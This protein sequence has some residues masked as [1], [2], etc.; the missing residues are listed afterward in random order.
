MRNRFFYLRL[1]R[2]SLAL[3]GLCDLACAGALVLTPD[4]VARTLRVPL[5]GEPFYLW[6]LAVL[7]SMV[8]ALYLFAAEDPRR[9]PAI[10][11]VAT[12]GR[13]ACAGA[14]ALAAAGDPPLPG[15]WPAAGVEL[16]FGLAHGWLWSR[17][18]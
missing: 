7:L 9:Y 3:G 17:L 6:F 1:L 11:L 4:V 12:A 10:V 5:P 8:A 14:L 2:T 13:C 15:R 18:R 16:G